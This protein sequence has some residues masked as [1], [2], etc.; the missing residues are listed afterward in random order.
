MD[1]MDEKEFALG[2]ISQME[3]PSTCDVCY[4]L[5]DAGIHFITRP[6]AEVCPNCGAIMRPTHDERV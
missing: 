1:E 6:Y 2:D 4:E 5:F 3:S